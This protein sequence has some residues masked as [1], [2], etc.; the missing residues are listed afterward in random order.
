MHLYFLRHGKAGS[1]EAWL[2]A[3]N[4]DDDLRPLTDKGREQLKRSLPTLRA[5]DMGIE[6]IL[7]SPLT[8]AAQTAAIAAKGLGLKDKLVTDDRLAQGTL[9]A[10]LPAILR[11]YAD[12]EAL[13]LVG[14][15]PDFSA[16]I[17]RLIGGAEVAMKKGGLARVDLTQTTPPAGCLVWLL[18]PQVLAV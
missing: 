16:T 3:G 17:G 12:L 4:T 5:L 13:L 6:R 7:T 2:A 11:D 8:R 9:L 18:P 1:T 15:E 10:N 14:H